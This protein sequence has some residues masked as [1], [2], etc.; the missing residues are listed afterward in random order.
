VTN[1][2]PCWQRD[3]SMR[4]IFSDGAAVSNPRH[5]KDP[6]PSLNYVGSPNA[7]RGFNN[8]YGFDVP[9][10]SESEIS[11]ANTYSDAGSPPVGWLTGPGGTNDVNEWP[12]TGVNY[13]ADYLKPLYPLLDPL[14]QRK[15]YGDV[16]R[17]P[18]TGSALFDPGSWTGFR[19][20]LYGTEASG[21]WYLLIA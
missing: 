20:G 13:G 2:Y 16:P 14:F 1:K 10:T 18:N 8:A 15:R 21:T 9:W 6:S 12:T 4:T 5:I 19:P 3:R 17:R 11:G 7:G